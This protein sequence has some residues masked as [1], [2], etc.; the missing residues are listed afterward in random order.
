MRSIPA[1]RGGNT[2]S[3]L[4]RETRPGSRSLRLADAK[5]RSPAL[6]DSSECQKTE[7]TPTTGRKRVTRGTQEGFLSFSIRS[8]QN[9]IK[10]LKTC[11][12]W[13]KHVFDSLRSPALP[14][15]CSARRLPAG[16]CV[17]PPQGCYFTFFT[18]SAVRAKRPMALGMTIRL[19]N[20]SDSSHTRSLEARVPRKTNTRAISV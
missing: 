3:R 5:N 6:P 20:I 2:A 4:F 18:T 16:L 14:D 11:S 10:V 13:R 9:F 7:K 19:L 1:A 15:S 8:F 17:L 12:G